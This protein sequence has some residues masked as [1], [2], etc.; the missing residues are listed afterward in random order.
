MFC[1][2]KDTKSALLSASLLYDI[3]IE[4]VPGES[5]NPAARTY[6]SKQYE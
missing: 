4:T 2:A 6:N 3:C 5:L 1:D